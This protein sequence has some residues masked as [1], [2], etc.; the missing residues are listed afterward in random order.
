MW[1]LP[2]LGAVRSVMKLMVGNGCT[3]GLLLR[4]NLAAATSRLTSELGIIMSRFRISL[5]V[6][7]TLQPASK[8]IVWC[9]EAE[10]NGKIETN[11]AFYT[12]CTCAKR[13]RSRKCRSLRLPLLTHTLYSNLRS[14]T[15]YQ[16]TDGFCIR[17]H[18]DVH[19]RDTIGCF[20]LTH[21]RRRRTSHPF[22]LGGAKFQ[23]VTTHDASIPSRF[24]LPPR[25]PRPRVERI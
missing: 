8:N 20:P 12:L 6:R 24:D 9:L 11:L 19:L 16:R 2:K 1:R 22:Q 4:N 15:D 10:A 17:G 7:G 25:R 21:L 18:H 5:K 14:H 3:Y 13:W 23:T